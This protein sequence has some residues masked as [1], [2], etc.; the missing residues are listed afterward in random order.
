MIGVIF[1]LDG[2]LADT[3]TDITRALNHVLALHGLPTYDEPAVLRMV[4]DGRDQLIARAAPEVGPALRAALLREYDERYLE[5][6]IEA[7]CPYRGIEQLLAELTA[8]RVPLGVLSNKPDDAARALAA[9]LFPT[10]PFRAVRGQRPGTPLKPDPTEALELAVL[11]GVKPGRCILV[12]DSGVDIQ[13]A[14]AAGM[15]PV[16]AAWGFRGRAELERLGAETVLEEP[17]DLLTVLARL[18]Q[19]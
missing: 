3:A 1:D 10:V 4:G 12:G 15:K 11:L 19:R 16:G 17:S 5:H 6:M 8:R 2:T 14:A 18:E 13:T 7:T 9:A